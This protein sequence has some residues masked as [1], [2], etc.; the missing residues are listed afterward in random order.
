MRSKPFNRGW[1]TEQADEIAVGGDAEASFGAEV[2]P[3]PAGADSSALDDLVCRLTRDRS[4]LAR[5][6]DEHRI[7]KEA[8]EKSP[9]AYCV[10]AADDRLVAANTAYERIHPALGQLRRARGAHEAIYYAD[11]VRL[12]L[13]GRVPPE[14]LE[15]AILERVEGQR[16]AD[17]TPVERDFGETGHFRIIKYPLSAGGTAGVAVDITELKRRE[18]ELIAAKSAAETAT[19]QAEAA[20]AN[21]VSRKH[22]AR[23]LSELS[24]WLQSCKSLDELFLV[25]ERFMEK[26]FPSANGELYI[27]SNSRDVLDGVCQWNRGVGLKAH[28][29]PDDCWALRRGRL[30]KHGAGLA[31]LACAHAD[32]LDGSGQQ[33]PYVCLPIIAHGDTVGLLHIRF[34]PDMRDADGN[35]VSPFDAGLH[36]FAIQCSE[37]ISLAIAN[38]KLRDELRDRSMKDPL[39]GLFNRRHFLDECWRALNAAER[40][41]QPIS[42]ISLDADNFKMF[43]D[44]HGHDAGDT[45]L[46]AIA[47]AMVQRFEPP[48]LVAR[49]G[50]EEF[51][52]LVP[53]ADMDAAVRQ[54]EELRATVE[55]MTIRY[56]SQSLPKI[57]I[58]AGV[59]SY[60][61]F[62]RTPHQLLQ[63]A[64]GAM[65]AAKNG[66]RNRVMKAQSPR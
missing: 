26:L 65:Y 27:Y 35:R 2:V 18:A 48:A 49:F 37:Q 3:L 61:T 63:T 9:M 42:L 29:Q 34:D 25:I 43:N 64:D 53:G 33:S 14:Q 7:L 16:N 55:S 30:F 31:D 44:T 58:S 32:D 59:S 41:G 10:Y 46:Q 6:V 23:L 36:S 21:E 20:L 54:A 57:T 56:G 5:L 60:P 47:E 1:P 50:G 39:T 40:S 52:I 19:A 4:A 15:D 28:I 51:S 66:G 24:D 45:V 62:G 11:V 17:G 8:I 12:Q 38:V 13:S 22:E